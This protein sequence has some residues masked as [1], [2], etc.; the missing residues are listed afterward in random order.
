M[1]TPRLVVS[2]TNQAPIMVVS[3]HFVV[4][5]DSILHVIWS[6]D[7]VVMVVLQGS[8]AK[9]GELNETEAVHMA[10]EKEGVLVP[11]VA[12][13]LVVAYLHTIS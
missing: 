2:S 8:M 4:L 6:Y 1:L 3:V 13:N 5:V 9:I 10:N 12:I 11:N 7:L